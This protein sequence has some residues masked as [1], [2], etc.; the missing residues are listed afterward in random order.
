M[1]KF[2]TNACGVMLLLNLIQVTV[3]ISGS[4]VPLAMFLRLMGEILGIFELIGMNIIVSSN[5][6]NYYQ[7]IIIK[8]FKKAKVKPAVRTQRPS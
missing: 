6:K 5:F 7:Q 8:A 2:A 3:S 1:A 4:A